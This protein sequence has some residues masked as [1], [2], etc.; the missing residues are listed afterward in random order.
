MRVSGKICRLCLLVYWLFL[1]VISLLPA[2]D[3]EGPIVE[4]HLDKFGHFGAYALLA[5]LMRSS[6]KPARR[7]DV[8]SD[9]IIAALCSVYGLVLEIIQGSALLGREFSV[10]D[11]LSNIAG[12]IA[13]LI[14][15][16]KVAKRSAAVE[17]Q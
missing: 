6:L 17:V 16:R 13:V 11:A 15:I 12:V 2:H 8:M 1:T 10:A 4:G 3:A 5:F 14:I 7:G 9:L